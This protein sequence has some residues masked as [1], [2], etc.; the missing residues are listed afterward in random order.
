MI[1]N[2]LHMGDI[3][4]RSKHLDE[5]LRCGRFIVDKGREEVPDLIIIAGDVFDSQVAL[6]SEVVREGIR[7]LGQLGDIA[8]MIMVQGTRTHDRDSLR[9][10][11]RLKTTHDTRISFE[12]ETIVFTGNSFLTISSRTQ[13]TDN[14]EIDLKQ[15]PKLLISTLPAPPRLAGEGSLEEQSQNIARHLETIITG[16]GASA[17]EFD[18]PHVIAGHVS[19]MGAKISDKQLMLGMDVELPKGAF[20]SAKANLICLGHI[21][22]AQRIGDNLFYCGS[23][24]RLNYGE[25]EDK[26]FWMHKLTWGE[27]RDPVSQLLRVER[28]SR[29]IETPARKMILIDRDLTEGGELI[30][31]FKGM[32]TAGDFKDLFIRIRYRI[33]EKDV[34]RLGRKEVEEIMSRKDAYEVKIEVEVVPELRV[35]CENLVTAGTLRQKIEAMPREEPLSESVLEKADRLEDQNK[36]E[37]EAE[38]MNL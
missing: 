3:H 19:V 7:L 14:I 13:Q 9:A 22:F 36:E 16:F 4:L 27:K 15:K 38:V 20:A 23:I 10:L 21:H 35:R 11:E 1:T 33:K 24:S 28:K 8:P 30:D 5:I 31:Q 25:D 18:C 34:H 29:F 12:P 6:D 2:I 26:G 32:L 37:I 17:A